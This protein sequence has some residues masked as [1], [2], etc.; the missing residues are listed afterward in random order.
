MATNRIENGAS[1]DVTLAADT[2]PGSVV[3][4]GADLAGVAEA[5]G[6]DGQLASVT[7][8]GVYALPKASGGGTG[9]AQGIKAYYDK[10]TGKVVGAAS[11]TTV[12]LG[13]V[14][15]VAKDADDTVEVRLQAGA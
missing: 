15:R 13:H 14:F 6:E 4:I 12:G 11:A 1:L 8:H 3:V 10:T 2:A 5:G 7:F 9:L